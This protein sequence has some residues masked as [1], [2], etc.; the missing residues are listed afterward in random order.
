MGSRYPL[1]VGPEDLECW[2]RCES[3]SS[4]IRSSTRPPCIENANS[5]LGR[6]SDSCFRRLVRQA[7]LHDDA[8]SASREEPASL[9]VAGSREPAKAG[10]AAVNGAW[11]EARRE[12][13]RVLERRHAG[14]LR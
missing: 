6:P 9:A 12:L 1:G 5:A 8:A 2:H 14:R 10:R 11:V 7:T 3:E 4:A 13:F